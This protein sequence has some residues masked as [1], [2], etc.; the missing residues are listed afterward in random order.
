MNGFCH[1]LH[2]SLMSTPALALFQAPGNR[3]VADYTA[4][5]DAGDVDGAWEL[6]RSLAQH[7]RAFWRWMREPWLQRSVVPIAYL[8]AWLGLMGL[9]QG[10]VRPPL[11]PLTRE[12]EYQLRQELEALELVGAAAHPL[13]RRKT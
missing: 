12:E 5:A 2:E 7:R 9:P 6:Q 8:K 11:V 10:P 1:E 13:P 4:L 3:P